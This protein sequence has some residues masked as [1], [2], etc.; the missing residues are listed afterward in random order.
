MSKQ[1]IVLGGGNISHFFKEGE[2]VS[3][4][5]KGADGTAS[6]YTDGIMEQYLSDDQVKAVSVTKVKARKVQAAK[7]SVAVKA[8]KLYAVRDTKD[9]LFIDVFATRQEAR[10]LKASYGG[11]KSGVEIIQY[12][13]AAKIR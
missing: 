6:I 13:P 11:L 12:T 5:H 3:L 10:A 9:G 4:L 8:S 1:F 7:K 2:V